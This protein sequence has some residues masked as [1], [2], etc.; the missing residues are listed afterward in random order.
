[1]RVLEAIDYKKSLLG[2]T[3]KLVLG[4]P[5]GEKEVYF[6]KVRY[7]MTARHAFQL[8]P[9]DNYNGSCWCIDV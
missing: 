1:M 5:N 6:L 8:S 3:T 2:T 9:T 7:P 4:L